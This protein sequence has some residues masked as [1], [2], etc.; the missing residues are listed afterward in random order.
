MFAHPRFRFHFGIDFFVGLPRFCVRFIVQRS[1]AVL[2]LCGLNTAGEPAS[3]QPCQGFGYMAKL[4]TLLQKGSLEGGS[5]LL[6]P[7]GS[8]GVHGQN[9]AKRRPSGGQEAAQTATFS[10]LF[11]KTFLDRF[12][13]DFPP[14]LAPSWPPKIEEN[15]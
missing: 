3:V 10:H 5:A 11:F 15:R 9:G 7:R 8:S 2:P 14:N 4:A 1:P 6:P 13:V 12:F